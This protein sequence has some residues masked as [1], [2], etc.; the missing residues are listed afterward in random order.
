MS[1]TTDA[2]L[3]LHGALGSPYSMKIRALLRY[4][5]IPHLWV[6]GAEPE[7]MA[8]LFAQV[9]APVIPVVAFPDGAVMN[10]STPLAFELERRYAGRSVIP[11][12]PAQAF[13]ALL[14][15]DMADEWGTKAMFHYRWFRERDQ[16][17]MGRWLLF[18][19]LKG[20]GRDAI[21]TAA[22]AFRAR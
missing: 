20:Q 21:E 15:E 9:K 10:D 14:L 17:Q 22:E 8:R 16:R 3:R 11:D 5:R 2:M 18:G 6:T 1:T 19:R 4:R 13:L 12:D 7:T